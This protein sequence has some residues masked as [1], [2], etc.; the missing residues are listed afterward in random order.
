MAPVNMPLIFGSVDVEGNEPLAD[1][2]PDASLDSARNE[3]FDKMIAE[4]SEVM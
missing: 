1:S 2:E 3:H 4:E